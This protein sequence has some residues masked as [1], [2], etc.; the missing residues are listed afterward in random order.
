MGAILVNVGLLHVE[1]DPFIRGLGEI[2][3]VMIMFALGFE[4]Q[5]DNFLAS[6]KKSWGI[7]FFGALAPFITAYA[8]ADYFFQDRSIALMCGLTMMATA[9]SLTMVSLRDLGLHRTPAATRIITSAVLDDIA[10]LALVAILVPVAAGETDI[11]T[12]SIL[13]IVLKAIA[14]FVLVTIAGAWLL[15]V[16]MNGILSSIP[17]FGKFGIRHLLAF[18]RG[19]NATLTVLLLAVLVG[20][21]A[22]YFGFHPAVG[23]YMAGLVLKE[24]YFH[25]DGD[26]QSYEHTRAVIDSFAFYSIGP[27]FFVELG[28]KLVFDWDIFVSVIPQIVIMTLGLFI[29]QIGSAALAARFTSGLEWPGSVMVGLGMLGRAE[30]AFVVMDIAYVQ[31]SILS[32]EAFYTLMLTAFWLNILV[33]VTISLWKP[34]YLGSS[35]EEEEP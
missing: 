19:E 2:G 12:V 21:T 3:I 10:A 4:E 13:L 27:V 20:I 9:V 15:P 11:N 8:V 5:T 30:L 6:I 26:T 34:Y 24:E 32:I 33:P 23:A 1:S 17:F 28:S 16:R 25:V 18:A 14:F 29:A 22:H 31:N 7:A 35:G